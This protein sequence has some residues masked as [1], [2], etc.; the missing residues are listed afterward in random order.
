MSVTQDYKVVTLTRDDYIVVLIALKA[1]ERDLIEMLDGEKDPKYVEIFTKDL[2]EV[3]TAF[4]K[5][6]E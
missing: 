1:R 3:R 6:K 4:A 5:V 2:A